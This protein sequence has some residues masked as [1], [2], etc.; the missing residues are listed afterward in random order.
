MLP[1]KAVS[2]IPGKPAQNLSLRV[3]E[4]PVAVDI[5]LLG[6]KC[7]HGHTTLVKFERVNVG[8]SGGFV[9]RK[10]RKNGMLETWS[11]G[12]MG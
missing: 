3:D 2:D 5:I 7:S 1:A 8:E 10:S 9:K 4:E 6:H 12:M 11:I